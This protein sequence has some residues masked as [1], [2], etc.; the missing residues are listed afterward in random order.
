MD[1][2]IIRVY[3]RNGENHGL[4]VGTVEEVG[5]PGKKR[6]SDFEELK[7][8]LALEDRENPRSVG[9]GKRSRNRL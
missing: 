7:E 5:V 1:C 6:F 9:E 4:L 3:R 2:Y 8:I